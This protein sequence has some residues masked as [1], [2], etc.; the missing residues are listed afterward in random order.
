RGEVAV[1]FGGEAQVGV[2][3]EPLH[4][5]SISPGHQEQ[6]GSAVTGVVEANGPDSRNRPEEAA[7]FRAASRRGVWRVLPVR[8]ALPPALVGDV[9]PEPRP[10]HGAAKRRTVGARGPDARPAPGG[11]CATCPL[12]QGVAACMV[13]NETG[14]AQEGRAMSVTGGRGG[15]T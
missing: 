12:A 1:S 6:A 5:D 15:S 13:A 4:R 11:I 10:G 2:A 3:H 14:N 7:V 9:R 8:A